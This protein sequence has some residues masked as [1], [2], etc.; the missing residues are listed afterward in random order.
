MANLA[1]TAGVLGVAVWLCSV[2]RAGA[3]HPWG[4]YHWE[5][6][7]NPVTVELGD[8]L[9]AHWK[10]WLEEASADW[11][12][13]TVLDTPVAGGSAKGKC[14]PTSGRVEVCNDAYGANGWLGIAQIWIDGDHIQKGVAKLNDTYHDTY[15]YN[16]PG[17][18]DLV[19]CQEVGHTF[20]LGHQ[21]ETFDNENLGTCMD[22]TSTPDGS[23]PNRQPDAH[24]YQQLEALYSHLDADADA[25]GEDTS[26]C[27]GPAWRCAGAVPPGA[28]FDDPGQW[29]RRVAQSR[30]GGQSVF[31]QD[32]GRGLRVV[33]HVTWTLEAAEA[34][35]HE[36]DDHAH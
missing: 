15:P 19:M 29:G 35:T 8:N 31:V 9:G 21:D 25:G 6:G 22:Y 32:L 11:S 12:A 26:P 17:W 16:Q 4:N 14:R 33:T 34:H 30:D 1:K 13:S 36:E 3:D 28:D 5:R 24:D 2:P 27:R 7:S 20:G 23:P 18:R 10:N